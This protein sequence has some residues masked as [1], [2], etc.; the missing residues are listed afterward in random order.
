MY[1]HAIFLGGG[2][3]FYAVCCIDGPPQHVI[4]LCFKSFLYVFSR[5]LPVEIIIILIIV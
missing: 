5:S 2:A 1:F 3:L 4:F